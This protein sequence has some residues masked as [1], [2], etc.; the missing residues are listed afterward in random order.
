MDR[1]QNHFYIDGG[2][3]S[4][5]GYILPDGD[6]VQMGGEDH[7]EIKKLYNDYYNEEDGLG[8]VE[9]EKTREG[10]DSDYMLDFMDR[11][12]AVRFA[13][14]RGEL[15]MSSIQKLTRPQKRM[16]TSREYNEVYWTELNRDYSTRR[17]H[18]YNTYEFIEKMY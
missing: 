3:L 5:R 10:S 1:I 13:V 9:I 8:T 6:V 18:H 16:L 2:E 11:V 15:V 14:V 12:G 17:E 7:R 4:G